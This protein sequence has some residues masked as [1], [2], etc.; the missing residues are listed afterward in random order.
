[1]VWRCIVLFTSYN[2]DEVFVSP[3][4]MATDCV[5][6]SY[7]G[8]HYDIHLEDKPSINIVTYHC[9]QS[10]ASII[11]ACLGVCVCGMTG[12]RRLADNA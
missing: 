3:L 1:M 9:I 11:Q 8:L 7:S 10:V 6:Y 12:F 4:F 2:D 5:N